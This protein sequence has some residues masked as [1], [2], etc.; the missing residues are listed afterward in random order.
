MH[1]IDYT[2]NKDALSL[3][4]FL[5]ALCVVAVWGTNFV[6]IKLGLGSMPPLMFAALRFVLVFFPAAI[7][8]HRPKMSLANL[9]AYGVLIGV[10][11]F[12]LLYIAMNGLISPGLA[13]LVVQSQVFFTIGLAAWI[14]H[15]RV[16]AHQVISLIF[17]VSGI[18]IVAIN[19][20]GSTTVGGI[21]LVLCA[22]LSWAAA[23][24]LSKFARPS[25][26]LAY[27]VWSSVFS[28]PPLIVLSLMREGAPLIYLALSKM[29][30]FSW[31]TVL[32]QSW[33][34]TLFGYVAWG[35]L[36]TRYPAAT[37]APMALLV[38]VFGMGA[39]TLFLNEPFPAWKFFA[40]AFVM[41]GLSI[42]IL[43][44]NFIHYVKGR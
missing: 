2:A 38:P 29:S 17:A 30:L 34:N 7:V 33:G 26:M 19:T 10:G 42:N 16:R 6:V 28:V 40:A 1:S 43:W 32:W 31:A 3:R 41:F 11:Q 25:N 39:S 20:D 5:L 21:A 37:V 23:N 13:S 15:E 12:G 8:I 24:I 27:V 9:A 36:L 35:V 14:A 44:P 18:A 22:A 4:H